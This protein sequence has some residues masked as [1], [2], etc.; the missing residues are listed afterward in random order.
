MDAVRLYF[1]IA[2]TRITLTINHKVTINIHN[3]SVN[4]A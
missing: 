3:S 1:M 2:N 4:P